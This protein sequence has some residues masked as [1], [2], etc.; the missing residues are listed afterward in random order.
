MSIFTKLRSS[1]KTSKKDQ[2]ASEIGI[3]YSVQHRI[4]VGFNKTTGEIEG[5]PEPWLRLLQHANIRWK[6][7]HCLY[8]NIEDISH[9][10]NG[11]LA[12]SGNFL[13]I[14]SLLKAELKL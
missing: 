14:L 1:K 2:G 11:T 5:L 4:H 12:E 9:D 13:L 6:I 3:P 8:Y 10:S 7:F